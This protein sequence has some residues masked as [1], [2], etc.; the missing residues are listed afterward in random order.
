MKQI[1]NSW[2]LLNITVKI[3]S[4]ESQ[5]KFEPQVPYW[6]VQISL[7]ETDCFINLFG[8]EFNCFICW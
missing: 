6:H 5:T 8:E 7:K 2:I 1:G 4:G 3:N